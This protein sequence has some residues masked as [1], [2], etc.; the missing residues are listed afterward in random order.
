MGLSADEVVLITNMQGG[1]ATFVSFKDLSNLYKGRKHSLSGTQVVV[2]NR[3]P[4]ESAV[5]Y[6]FLRKFL[7][8]DAEQYKLYWLRESFRGGA[9][10]PRAVHSL[11][12][13]ILLR[14]T[15]ANAISYVSLEEWE[16]LRE[17]NLDVK[18][19]NVDG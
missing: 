2:V 15:T 1:D 9:E 4:Y 12:E 5:A 14:Q 19:L 10:E 3:Q 8:L 6:Q 11:Q 16:N 13:L 18:K 7:G 17:A